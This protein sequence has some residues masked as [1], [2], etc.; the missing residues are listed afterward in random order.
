MGP[1]PL[2]P[3][4]P[5][6][7]DAQP[8]SGLCSVP[9]LL[10][11]HG[12]QTPQISLSLSLSLY[13][14]SI[15]SEGRDT[16]ANHWSGLNVVLDYFFPVSL[17][18]HF[19]PPGASVPPLNR[20]YNGIYFICCSWCQIPVQCPLISCVKLVALF[21]AAGKFEELWRRQE[22]SLNLDSYY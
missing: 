6:T 10:S 21:H 17:C 1:W 19:N 7:P 9:S 15:L 13:P 11:L 18:P 16:M 8:G 20:H 4:S 2:T 22:K 5:D 12:Q 14:S 3:L